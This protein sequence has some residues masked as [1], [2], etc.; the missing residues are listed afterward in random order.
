MRVAIVYDWAN[1]RTGG[2]ERVLKAL[3]QI[4][5]RAPLFTSVFKKDLS[6]PKEFPS[7]RTSFID[8]IPGARDHHRLFA[9]L[10][11]IGFEQFNLDSFDLVVSLSSGP[12]KGI[13]TKPK[14]CHINYCLTPPRYL[15]ERRFL[16]PEALFPLLSPLRKQDR[17]LSKRPDFYLAISKNVNSRIRRFYQRKAEVVYPG[18][19]LKQFRIGKGRKEGEPFFLLVSR[20][21]GYKKGALVVRTFNRLE[22]RLKVIGIGREMGRLK[23]M[24]GKNISFLGEVD[25]QRLVREYQGCQALIFPQEEDFGLTPIE[26]QACGRPVIAYRRGGAK[27]TVIEGVTGQFFDQQTEE[28]LIKAVKR[29]DSN[30]YR[31]EN[32]RKNA[33]RFSLTSFMVSFKKK[34]ERLYQEYWRGF[35]NEPR[36]LFHR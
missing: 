35:K 19:D 8:K 22:Q 23:A 10:I 15:W 9:P 1:R 7:V 14:T 33:E 27:E 3:H 12:A 30:K 11:P 34:V 25:D 18:V 36:P 28:S 24:A 17:L 13:I 21:V 29:F 6:W 5:P 4:W 26:A 20:L 32:C 16:T 2:A 31:P